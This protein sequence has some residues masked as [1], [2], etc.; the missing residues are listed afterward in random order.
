MSEV[1]KQFEYLLL[2]H[3]AP[4]LYGAKSANLFS[5]QNRLSHDLPR[6]I[7]TYIHQFES[8]GVELTVLCSCTNSSLVYVYRKD[9]LQRRL[10]NPS[11][12]EFL[13]EYGYSDFSSTEVVLDVLKSRVSQYETFPHEIGVFLDY[14]LGD[15]KGFIKN[16]G[17]NFKLS[18]YWKVYE[19]EHKAAC[20][21]NRY[22]ECRRDAC[23]KHTKGLSVMEI[24]QS[25]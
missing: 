6:I 18:G 24:M 1:K 4:T 19:N 3:C 22:T 13:Q 17:R 7:G 2:N 10:S 20:L 25:A 12:Q 5:I 21:F 23:E 14:P 15:V 11:V 8:F 9:E 16:N